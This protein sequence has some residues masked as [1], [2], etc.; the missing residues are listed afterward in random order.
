MSGC[1]RLCR[2]VIRTFDDATPSG[3]GWPASSVH[4]AMQVSLANVM[5]GLPGSLWPTRPS[6]VAE[7]LKTDT[8][9]AAPMAARSAGLID[10][11]IEVTERRF[12]RR[13]PS[14]CSRASSASL[15]AY[16]IRDGGWAA[17]SRRTISAVGRLAGADTRR[18]GGPAAVAA[19]RPLEWTGEPAPTIPITR[20]AGGGP[21]E[22]MAAAMARRLT[23]AVNSANSP[24]VWTN[25][26]RRPELP[27][28]SRQT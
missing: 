21:P 11:D 27:P 20:P 24:M 10:S 22:A 9:N 17:L 14:R 1:V 3:T 4:S 15:A 26:P 2:L 6:V 7:L 18:T 28:D 19:P 8:P 5:T 12:S 13:R 25:R 16:A 23:E